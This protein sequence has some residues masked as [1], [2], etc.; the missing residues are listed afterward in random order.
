MAIAGMYYHHPTQSPSSYQVKDH[1]K[2]Q[3]TFLILHDHL[4]HDL[5]S[6]STRPP[7]PPP[8]EQAA[9]RV[10]TN[11]D[12]Q[13]LLSVHHKNRRPSL[14]T[15][16]DYSLSSSDASLSVRPHHGSVQQPR[17]FGVLTNFK[18]CAFWNCCR[19]GH[20][21]NKAYCSQRCGNCGHDICGTCSSYTN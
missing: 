4:S 2:S 20:V 6:L 16:A 1:N 17:G 21:N 5:S 3:I 14:A 15:M 18:K 19:C 7:Y 9:F 10:Q 11:S 12:P 13:H 8:S